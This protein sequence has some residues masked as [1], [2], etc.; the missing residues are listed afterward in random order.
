MKD[1]DDDEMMSEEEF[2]ETMRSIG[3]DDEFI[4]AKIDKVNAD[5]KN[6]IIIP[7][8][9]CLVEKPIVY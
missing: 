3:W 8:E 2:I 9:I 4:Q 6:G 7:Y 1:I 5:K